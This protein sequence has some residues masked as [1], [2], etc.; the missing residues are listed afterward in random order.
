MRLLVFRREKKRKRVEGI[1]SEMT[2]Y[3]AGSWVT[4][5]SYSQSYPTLHSFKP[6]LGN[7]ILGRKHERGEIKKYVSL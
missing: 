2:W 6:L 3:E 5:G 1:G 4:M 7:V